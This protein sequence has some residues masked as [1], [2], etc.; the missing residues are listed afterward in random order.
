MAEPR[1]PSFREAMLTPAQA[2]RLEQARLL[3]DQ[4]MRTLWAQLSTAQRSTVHDPSGAIGHRYPL[5]ASELASLAG[6]G[7]ERVQA[8]AASGVIPSWQLDGELRFES[9][10]LIAAFAHAGGGE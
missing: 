1:E 4:R 8:L 6:L 3:D 2:A 5:T 7:E 10:G 9:A